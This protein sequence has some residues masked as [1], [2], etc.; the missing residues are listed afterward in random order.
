MIKYQKNAPLG[1]DYFIT[2]F[3][4]LQQ[5]SLPTL[6]GVSEATCLFYGR[7]EMI[8]D[9][10]TE[11]PVVFISGSKY[12][13]IG[14]D[15]KYN[16]ISYLMLTNISSDNEIEIA[17]ASLYCHGN[18][19]NIFPTI[20]HRADQELRAAMKTFVLS[21]I[22]PQDFTNIEVINSEM[23]PFHSFKINFKINF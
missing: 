15:T 9:N 19:A 17:D 8:K 12:E 4:I 11:K 22:E 10:D 16:F 14:V 2:R 5:R 18:L 7:A 23:Q 13:P 1:L 3:Q 21:Q 20:S 6:F